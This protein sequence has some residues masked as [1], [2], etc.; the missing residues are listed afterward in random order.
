MIGLFG[1][2]QGLRQR[3]TDTRI[4]IMPAKRC[5]ARHT[6]FYTSLRVGMKV[7]QPVAGFDRSKQSTLGKVSRR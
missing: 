5:S 1:Y 7:T 4:G 6:R 2:E 3:M